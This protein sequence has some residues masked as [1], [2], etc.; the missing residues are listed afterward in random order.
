MARKTTYA[1]EEGK[2]AELGNAL[3]GKKAMRTAMI[4]PDRFEEAIGFGIY[5]TGPHDEDEVPVLLVHG[6][7]G[8]PRAWEYLGEDV[9]EGSGFE[10]WYAFYPS[11]AEIGRSARLMRESVAAMVQEHD[12]E[13]M[14]LVGHSQGGLV[15][16][17]ALADWA[18]VDGLPEVPAFVG[19]ST[20][21]GGSQAAGAGTDSSLA[22]PAWHDMAAG[23]GFVQ[24][25]YDHPLPAPTTFHILYGLGTE[26]DRVP[27]EDDGTIAETS[28]AWPP[29]RTE[30]TTIERFEELSHSGILEDPE[31]MGRVLEILETHAG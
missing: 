4:R 28:L 8:G 29:A 3:F 1:P 6:H 22:L 13:V 26:S 27:G 2:Y 18:E 15:I 12:V 24:T 31:A 11:G 16:R 20:P 5:L 21:W 23:S 17:K 25:L 9:L 30:A 7:G 10:P 14:A 19:I